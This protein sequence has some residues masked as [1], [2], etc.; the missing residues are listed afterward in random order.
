MQKITTTILT[1][2][3]KKG[4]KWLNEVKPGWYKD[5]D[6]E[7]LN[8]EEPDVCV[9]GQVFGSFFEAIYKVDSDTRRGLATKR[10]KTGMSW[11]TSF[12][13]G[14]VLLNNQARF[15]DT[16]TR[17]WYLEIMKLQEQD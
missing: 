8:L 10:R 11:I 9:C 16:L 3:V 5:I 1:R 17:I 2:R 13:R 14:F 4:I 15:Y 6:V 7:K 12:S